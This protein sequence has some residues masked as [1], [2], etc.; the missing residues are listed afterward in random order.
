MFVPA[1]V[2]TLCCCQLM[3]PATNICC[4]CWDWLW[5]WLPQQLI[6]RLS[7]LIKPNDDRP[8]IHIKLVHTSVHSFSVV[9]NDNVL[10]CK[11]TDNH[12][13]LQPKLSKDCTVSHEAGWQDA[14]CVSVNILCPPCHGHQLTTRVTH[15]RIVIIIIALGKC[16]TR[17]NK[18]G[19]E[20]KARREFI[21]I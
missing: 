6:A 19:N 9:V 3:W 21:S 20:S 16:L 18:R 13:I 11:C 8:G 17:N 12:N 14:L 4:C 10:E 5:C 2:T 15:Q 1:T 7:S